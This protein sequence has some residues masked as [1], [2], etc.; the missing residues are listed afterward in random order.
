MDSDPVFGY[1][2]IRLRGA[3]GTWQQIKLLF[4]PPIF[5]IHLQ[6]FFFFRTSVYTQTSISSSLR[7]FLRFVL[8]SVPV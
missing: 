1:A 3:D 4:I 5:V 7:V 8:H 2:E 6:D